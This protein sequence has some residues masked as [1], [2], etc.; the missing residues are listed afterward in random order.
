M[1]LLHRLVAAELLL[2]L[3][4][5]VALDYLVGKIKIG[6]FVLGGVAGTLLV[7]VI[8]GQLAV[9]IDGGIKGIFFALFRRSS[10]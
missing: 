10:G 2:A 7:G 1:D 3:F 4:V 9:N 5:T 8:V 6:S